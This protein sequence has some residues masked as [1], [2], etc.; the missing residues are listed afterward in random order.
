[1]VFE[2]PL[3]K[4]PANWN[5]AGDKL[6]YLEETNSTEVNLVKLFLDKAPVL[7][8]FS[9]PS[10][11]IEG[12]INSVYNVDAKNFIVLKDRRMPHLRSE[13][14]IWNEFDEN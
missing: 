11:L 4:P 5:I 8:K 13:S 10:A 3:A 2:R 1:M 7:F 12:R 9:L 6:L 14:L